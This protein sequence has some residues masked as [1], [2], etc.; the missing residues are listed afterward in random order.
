MA[1]LFSI[2]RKKTVPLAD[3]SWLGTDMH[4][5]L[6]PGLDDGAPDLESS[7]KLIRALNEM[8]FKKFWC[9]P[10]I[11]SDFY[12]NDASSIFPV[13]EAV[14]DA[15][16]DAGI[17]VEVHAAAEY[18]VDDGFVK[19][20]A[21]EKL[22]T[23]GEKHLLFEVSYINAP[24][25]LDKVIFDMQLKG[26]RPIMAHPERYPFWYRDFDKY[27]TFRDQ[28][29]MLQVNMNSLCGY[30]GPDAKAIALKMV[31]EGIVDLLGTDCHHERHLEG[32]K[33]G[34]KEASM[35]KLMEQTALFN[36]SL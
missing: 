5:H 11:M 4:S 31:E 1:S 9:T 16:K 7:L 26:Y 12:R 33:K 21:H 2:F 32:I 17:P 6:L 35:R 19:K 10:H 14:R 18:Y 23:L 30:Y 34:L 3:Y 24:E 20:L 25:N 29:V 22:L 15:V 28:G 27:K 36:A 13:L 8:G